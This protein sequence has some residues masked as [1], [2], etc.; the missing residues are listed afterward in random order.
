MDASDLLLVGAEVGVAI[1][2]FAG[3][4]TTYQ[5]RDRTK[6]NRS[7]VAGLSLIV[8]GSL[9]AAFCCVFPLLLSVFGVE[10]ST[11]W[12]ICSCVMLVGVGRSMFVNERD[13]RGVVRTKSQRL[14]NG[15]IQGVSF[16]IVLS[17]ILNTADLVFHREAG[18]YVFAILWGLSIT[19]YMFVRLLLRPLWRTVRQLEAA[20]PIGAQSS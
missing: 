16:L 9:G 7:Q 13:L 14:I 17:L 4:I 18:P 6:I 1:A 10:D 8:I 15:A 5:F 3:I 11:L 20:N 12:A 19:S 2:G